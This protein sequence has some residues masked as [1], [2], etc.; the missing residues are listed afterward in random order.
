MRTRERDVDP[1]VNLAELSEMEL[2]IL[3][4]MREF[5]IGEHRSLFH[6]T[7][8]DLV[9]LR[10]WQPGDLPN[11]IDWPQTTLTNFSPVLVRDFE[12]PST[13]TVIAVADRSLSTRCGAG[14]TSIATVIARA[15]GMIGMSA[16]FFQDMFGVI[17]FE[18]GFQ[19]LGAVTPRIGKNH[20]IRC[21]DAYQYG[22]NLQ[23]VRRADSLSE[24]IAG[25]MRK[26]SLVPVISDFLFDD[27]D[28][29]L[30]ELNEL[31]S[32]HDVF[33]VLVDSAFAFQLPPTPSG[34]IDTF[35][36]ES[37]RTRV[38]SRRAAKTLAAQASQWQ[39][40]VERTANSLDLDVLRVS[41]NEQQTAV[42][43]SEFITARRVRKA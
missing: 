29:I 20:V 12:Q 24:T 34:W 25:V 8:F 30:R 42:A 32:Y 14:E 16:V 13:A 17:T 5:T 26:T 3:K 27:R 37:G 40:E 18:A 1:L 35:D 10:A 41:G 43:I 33:L 28:E 7:G 11:A 36:V 39:D 15:I 4:R 23:D 21:L 38:L 22:R 19:Q 2:L 6:G 9:G 31:N